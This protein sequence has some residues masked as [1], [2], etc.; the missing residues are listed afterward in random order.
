M[1]F[2]LD[3]RVILNTESSHESLYSWSLQELD[4]D[5]K[6]IGRDQ[7][8]WD[9]SLY[10]TATQLSLHDGIEYGRDYTS[11]ESKNKVIR[12][13]Q[14]IQLALSPG[15]PA[16]RIAARNTVYSM[17]GT[18]R[19]ISDFSL[20][21]HAASSEQHESCIST[22]CVSF[23]S[24]IDFIYETAPD[25]VEFH[26]FVHPETFACYADKVAASQVDEAVF[27]VKGVEGFYSDWS[28]SISTERIKVL[29]RPHDHAIEIPNDCKIL[30]PKLREIEEAELSF[31]S[32]RNINMP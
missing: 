23:T 3:R 30:L 5:G 15:G 24:E 21:I 10:F 22:G 1:N 12:K 7:V 19:T 11:E 25:A 13:K 31:R 17:F 9:W 28:P 14:Y 32:V 16:D 29:T 20:R 26:L 18:D 8:P 27:R 2:H 4:D 6:Q